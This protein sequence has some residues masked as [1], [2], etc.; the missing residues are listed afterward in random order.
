MGLLV[1]LLVIFW[2]SLVVVLLVLFGIVLEVLYG[3]VG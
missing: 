1:N 2:W 3:G